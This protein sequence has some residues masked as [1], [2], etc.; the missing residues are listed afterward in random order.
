[1]LIID[2]AQNLSADVLEQL[3]LLTNLETRERTLLQ[4][5]LIG[6]PELRSMLARPELEQL[7]QR[8]IAR[9]HLEAL[10]E[11]ETA[12]Y[13][14]HRLEAAGLTQP[15]PF[16]RHALQRI[17]QRTR[18]VPRRIN[19]L[20]DRAL[21]GAF[22]GGHAR[23]NRAIV[24]KAASEVF[25]WQ[26]RPAL[27]PWKRTAA[28]LGVGLAAGAGLWAM[29]SQRFAPR[30]VSELPS[31]MV[32]RPAVPAVAIPVSATAPPPAAASQVALPA[33]PPPSL[34]SDE[35]QAWRE[36]ARAWKLV[37]G[38]GGACRALE[39]EQVQCFSGVM[40]LALIRQLGRPGIVTLDAQSGK[41]S[42]ALLTSL[43]ADSATLR[44]GNGEQTVTLPALAAR[45]RGE[46]AT[47]WRAPPGSSGRFVER[48]SGP[49]VDWLAATL[50][51]VNGRP[52]PDG[53]QS[54]DAALKSRVL[55]FQL[56]Q[57]LPADGRPGPM[58]FMQLNRAAGVDEPRLL[59]AP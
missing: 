14:Q 2:E 9:Y 18:G 52:A 59:T 8:V 24:D 57:G 55:A 38:E 20:C 49:A 7:A 36:L 26:L 15:S 54:L 48:D 21:L 10:G 16:D 50:A 39:R 37:P 53:R 30:P 44:A 22:A 1:M 19:L 34:L 6:Q 12:Q 25:D 23:V 31:A 40:N 28:V 27:A 35:D 3:R 47:L 46:F 42:Y 41:P 56:A 29:A 58:T 4:I 51:M 11:A 33:A 5:V 13:V 43:T 32:S 17:H 45:W